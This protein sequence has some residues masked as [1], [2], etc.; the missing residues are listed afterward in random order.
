MLQLNVHCLSLSK[1]PKIADLISRLHSKVLFLSESNLNS[2][3][4]IS[5]YEN[6]NRT[7]IWDS[8]NGLGEIIKMGYVVAGRADKP[9][10]VQTTLE[11]QPG[12][13]PLPK[14]KGRGGNSR[15][16]ST[17]G[18]IV[19]LVRL[20]VTHHSYVL[21]C[22]TDIQSTGLSIALS[23][24]VTMHFI[25]MYIQHQ[26]AFEENI[27]RQ[28]LSEIQNYKQHD[29]AILLGDFNCEEDSER[30]VT[31]R[32]W[33]QLVDLVVEK[34]AV[35]ISGGR[36]TFDSY[37]LHRTASPDHTIIFPP[38]RKCPDF[39]YELL[40]DQPQN[41]WTTEKVVDI[42]DHRAISFSCAT[43]GNIEGGEHYDRGR[44]AFKSLNKDE[45]QRIKDKSKVFLGNLLMDLDEKRNTSCSSYG[46]FIKGISALTKQEVMR[47]NHESAEVYDI[48]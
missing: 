29:I 25:H 2:E 24:S 23:N 11:T 41:T 16:R 6:A 22:S 47:K 34:K 27:F 38:R 40:F 9:A 31:K 43:E 7:S 3:I 14:R 39:N 26:A 5:S 36:I 1:G 44:F 30:T 8:R 13:Q 20:G 37:G 42:S 48:R 32:R 45:R 15:K 12:T 28:L 18:G 21:R 46:E 35:S 4:T 10:K 19:T 17:G 33:K